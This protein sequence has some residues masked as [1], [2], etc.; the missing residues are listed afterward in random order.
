MSVPVSV[1]ARLGLAAGVACL[2]ALL[3]DTDGL[4]AAASEDRLVG[5][6]LMNEFVHLNLRTHQLI[7]E[8]PSLRLREHEALRKLGAT[9]SR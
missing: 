1:W 8:N 4:L 2:G 7:A 6:S 3:V 5:D 9:A